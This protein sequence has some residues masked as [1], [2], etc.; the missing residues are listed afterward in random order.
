MAAAAH[1]ALIGDYDP[2]V[3]A[4]QAIPGALKLAGEAAPASCRPIRSS[5]GRSSN[6]NAPAFAVQPTP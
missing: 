5:S 3:I 6:P 4:H 2:Q 1:I